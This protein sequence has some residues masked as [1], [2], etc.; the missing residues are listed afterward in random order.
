MITQEF[1]TRPLPHPERAIAPTKDQID[2][3]RFAL[4]EFM[5]T[6]KDNGQKFELNSL[7]DLS[8]SPIGYRHAYDGYPDKELNSRVSE[9]WRTLCPGL[10]YTAPHIKSETSETQNRRIKIGFFYGAGLDTCAPDVSNH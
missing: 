8:N 7:I 3:D 9:F 2:A 10:N 1:N 5:E 6:T 4:E